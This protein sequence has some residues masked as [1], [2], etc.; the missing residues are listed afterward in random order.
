MECSCSN[1]SG[2]RG[3]SL[4]AR[5]RTQAQVA[6]SSGPANWF[7]L[8]ASPD[9]RQQILAT[10]PSCQS[11]PRRL[12]R[13]FPPSSSPV[14]TWTASWACFTSASFTRCTS[15]RLYRCD[16]SSR[17]KTASPRPDALE[18]ARAVDT[19]APDR[20]IPLVPPSS[21]GAKD[22]FFCKSRASSRWFPRPRE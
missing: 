16:V 19:L 7:L 14:P 1:C 12:A 3:G 21:P 20:L 2:L 10:S 11:H 15:T 22:G 13:L 9:L 8:N 17:K 5:P 18:P 4:K 6:V